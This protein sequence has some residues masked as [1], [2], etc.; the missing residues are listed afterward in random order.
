MSSSLPASTASALVDITY[1]SFSYYEEFPTIQEVSKQLRISRNALPTTPTSQHSNDYSTLDNTYICNSPFQG[2]ISPSALSPIY[3][4]FSDD[5]FGVQ[6]GINIGQLDR[7]QTSFPE[8]TTEEPVV[9]F[10]A[11]VEAQ[12]EDQQSRLLLNGSKPK[13]PRLSWVFQRTFPMTSAGE[14]QAI[15]ILNSL[16]TSAF[17]LVKNQPYETKEGIVQCFKCT[18]KCRYDC[19][20]KGKLVHNFNSQTIDAYSYGCHDHDQVITTS[21]KGL[22]R[23]DKALLEEAVQDGLEAAEIHRKITHLNKKKRIPIPTLKQVQSATSYAKTKLLSSLEGNTIGDLYRWC[24][25]NTLSVSSGKH[26]FGVLEGWHA[27]GPA[28]VFSEAADVCVVVTTKNLLANVKRQQRGNL[29]SFVDLDQTY[30]L[31]ENGYPMT[32][33]G[34]VDA[35]HKFHLAATALSRHE[36]EAANTLILQTI[37][38]ALKHLIN[39]DWNPEC[40]MA[41]RSQAISNSLSSVFEPS[42]KKA[43]CYF[44]VKKG[45]YDHRHLFTSDKNYDEFEQDCGT[46]A[47]LY[48]P[49]MFTFALQLLQRKWQNRERVA[50]TWFMAEWGDR[51]YSSW[52]S[53]F[54]PPGIPN[55]NVHVERFNRSVKK[56]V[57]KKQRLFQTDLQTTKRI[58][59]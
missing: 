44:H 49:E 12:M 6:L 35:N 51:K 33:V 43:K 5:E 29:V 40:G 54:T 22:L 42:I 47:K 55:T 32:V 11:E 9:Y 31:A 23:Q 38:N 21:K 36:D 39:F 20:F 34:T 41:D 2:V 46:I 28:D 30:S 8:H 45:L 24:S 13:K 10:A 52:F 50:V 37:K 58:D 15:S 57:T 17:P 27:S 18:G 59:L 16:S 19:G 53:G 3:D 14:A 25:K 4:S 1:G 26:Q 56:Y 48:D 7:A